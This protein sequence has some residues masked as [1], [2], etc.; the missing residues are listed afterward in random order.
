MALTRI[1]VSIYR[2]TE[3]QALEHP[4]LETI[5]SKANIVKMKTDIKF[6]DQEK[7]NELMNG[8][9]ASFVERERKKSG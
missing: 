9:Y 6:M 7:F 2:L 1:Y 3:K 8:V 5:K 4:A